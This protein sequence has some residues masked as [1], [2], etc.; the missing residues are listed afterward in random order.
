[1]LLSNYYDCWLLL[2]IKSPT[3]EPKLLQQIVNKITKLAEFFITYKVPIID[4]E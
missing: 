1:M 3:K 2:L 4:L